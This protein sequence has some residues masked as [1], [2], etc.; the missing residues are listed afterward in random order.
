MKLIRDLADSV[1]E[2]P[3]ALSIG[4]YDGVHLGHQYLIRKL[5]QSARASNLLAGV[6]TFDRHPDE[7]LASNKGLRYLTTFEEKLELLSKL[8]LDFVLALTFTRKLSETPARDFVLSLLEHLRLRELWIGPDF[9]LG[10]DR[11]GNEAYLR[12]LGKELDFSLHTLQPVMHQGRVISSS[13][14]RTLLREGK[15]GEARDLLGRYPSLRGRVVTGARRGHHLGFPTANLAVDER[16]VIPADG[17]YAVRAN[18][19]TG[20]HQAVANVGLRPTFE[21]RLGRVVE[22]HILDFAGGLYG[23]TLEVH[24]VKRLRPERRFESADALIAQMKE[25]VAETRHLFQELDL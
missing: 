25:D 19:G 21:D 1:L 5:I 14:I 7:L 13:A 20:N 11:Q 15:V 6:L 12:D 10:R 18:W 9:A 3:S 4:V 17:I 23:E 2:K 8:G 22:A 24:F 16:I